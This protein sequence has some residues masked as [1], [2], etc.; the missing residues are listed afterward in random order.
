MPLTVRPEESVS[1][2]GKE[3]SQSPDSS[4]SEEMRSALMKK[5]AVEKR[6]TSSHK[7]VDLKRV[8]DPKGI[9]VRFACHSTYHG[10]RSIMW[11]ILSFLL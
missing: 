3:S 2:D 9:P 4:V 5:V 11:L 7:K 10:T 1:Q 6:R 8:S